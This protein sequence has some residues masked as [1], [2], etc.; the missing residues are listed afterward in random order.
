MEPENQLPLLVLNHFQ[1]ALPCEARISL[2]VLAGPGSIRP[3]LIFI[4]PRGLSND[5]R[6]DLSSSSS[7]LQW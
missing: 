1:V 5:T 4:E 7:N 6:S 2:P 3:G